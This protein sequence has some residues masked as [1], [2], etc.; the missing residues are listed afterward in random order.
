LKKLGLHTPIA[1]FKLV[2]ENPE[3]ADRPN[4]TREVTFSQEQT[5]G[6]DDNKVYFVGSNN[7]AVYRAFKSKLQ[8]VLKTVD[9][10]R[11]P[12]GPFTFD[13]LKVAQI[14]Y[15]NP[16]FKNGLFLVKTTDNM[17]KSAWALKNPDSQKAVNDPVVADFIDN[18]AVLEALEFLK[19]DEKMSNREYSIEFRD[20]KGALL[21]K[22]DFGGMGKDAKSGLET[23][24]VKTSLAGQIVSVRKASIDKLV[25]PNLVRNINEPKTVTETTKVE[26]QPKSHQ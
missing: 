17:G 6:A 22:M 21:F 25:K 14:K 8:G 19:S 13:K 2:F 11:D 3:G 4:V 23:Y 24:L 10:M 9:S 18:V 26:Q 5:K 16:D 15:V 12:K 7:G 1:E 20:D